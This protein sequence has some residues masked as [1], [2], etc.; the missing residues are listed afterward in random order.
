MPTIRLSILNLLILF[1]FTSCKGQKPFG[2]ELL[3]LEKEI[4]MP[5]VNGRIDHMAVNLKDKILYMAALGN[6]TVEVID[7]VNG[8]LIKSIKG[9]E[10][11]QG[12]AYIQQQNEIVVSS[13]GNGDCVFF[14]ATSFENIATIHLAGDADNIRYDATERKIYVGYSNGAMA[15]IGPDSP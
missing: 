5:D 11:P 7:L 2:T 14:N 10:E 12:I 4:V 8:A 6:N 13:G 15:M 1:N 3:T 9:V